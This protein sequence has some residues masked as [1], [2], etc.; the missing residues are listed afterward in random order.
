MTSLPA[1]ARGCTALDRRGLVVRIMA[2][3]TMAVD[4]VRSLQAAGGMFFDN[5]LPEASAQTRAIRRAYGQGEVIPV[6]TGVL[7]TTVKSKLLK[8]APGGAL[9]IVAYSP[10][11]TGTLHSCNSYLVLITDFV[12][13]F[14]VRGVRQAHLVL[15]LKWAQTDL[16]QCDNDLQAA[17]LTA[18]RFPRR[19]RRHARSRSCGSRPISTVGTI[20]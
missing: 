1:C 14:V 11:G 2:A 13:K 19:R 18:Q 10:K 16:I 3:A 15:V 6:S 9:V 4:P 17:R 8:D 7:S 5:I 12:G 20:Y